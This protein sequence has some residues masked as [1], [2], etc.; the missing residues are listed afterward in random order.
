LSRVSNEINEK[1]LSKHQSA[2]WPDWS[3]VIGALR[4]LKMKIEWTHGWTGTETDFKSWPKSPGDRSLPE[5]SASPSP[6][7]GADQ[8][9][10]GT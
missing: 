2:L 9:F 7:A 5:Y 10:G 8:T 3:L 4:N 1:R 6:S